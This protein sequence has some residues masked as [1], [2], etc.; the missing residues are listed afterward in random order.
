MPITLPPISRRRILTGALAGGLAAFCPKWLL[1]AGE[2]PI[3]PHRIA[4]L[5]DVH[6]NEDKAFKYKTGVIPYE[7]MGQAI[8]EILALEKQP[9]NVIVN[10]DCA[11][12]NGNPGDYTAFVDGVE[13]LRKAGMPVHLVLGN[14]DR[15]ENFFKGVWESTTRQKDETIVDRQVSI[16]DAG[17][18]SIIMLDSL[19]Q[20]NKT[21]GV[22]G[23]K[24]L[25]W[26]TKALDARADKTLM[27]FIHHDP[28]DEAARAASK[29]ALSGLTDTKALMDII[30]PRKQV[31]AYVFGHTHYWK[32]IDMQGMHLVNLPPTAWVF[33]KERP[34]GWVDLSLRE[35]G[36]TFELHALDVKHPQHGEKFECKWR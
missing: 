30:L 9:A 23:E 7:T 34:Q 16:I 33:A 10:G 32:H 13:P 18:A 22:L 8:K 11:A 31:K 29:K 17:R 12:H 27:L 35:D 26:L 36:A 20:T 5:S 3:D 21:P 28:D 4:L 15:R 2:K 6:V 19:D 1:A 14:H 24:Q 25:A